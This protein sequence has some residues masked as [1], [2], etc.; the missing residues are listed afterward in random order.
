MD[1]GFENSMFIKG[2]P[3]HVA[4]Y[5]YTEICKHTKQANKREGLGLYTYRNM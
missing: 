3:F 1:V 2:C 5:I 4:V